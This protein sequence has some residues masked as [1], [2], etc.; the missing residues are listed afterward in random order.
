MAPPL[1]DRARQD[2]PAALNALD[3]VTVGE[4]GG[5]KRSGEYQT[6]VNN[7]NNDVRQ[8][9]VGNSN[10]YALRKLRKDREDLHG[11]VLAGLGPGRASE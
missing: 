7:V 5:D 6:N 9:P 10:T 8:S 11:R 4:Q 1:L 2:D 3:R